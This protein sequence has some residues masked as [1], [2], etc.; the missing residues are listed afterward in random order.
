MNWY[1]ST[2]N[3]LRS[4]GTRARVGC[5]VAGLSVNRSTY[6]YIYV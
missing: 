4:N 2:S 6:T 1:S 5:E 3:G